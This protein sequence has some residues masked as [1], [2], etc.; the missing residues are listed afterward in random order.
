MPKFATKILTTTEDQITPT[1]EIS[2]IEEDQITPDQEHIQN[3]S[4]HMPDQKTKF[5]QKRG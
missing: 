1:I 4:N 3:Q 2:T 5:T